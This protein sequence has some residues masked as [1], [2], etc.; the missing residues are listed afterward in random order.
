VSLESI[1]VQRDILNFQMIKKSQEET[2]FYVALKNWTA[3]EIQVHINFTDP[4][5][6]SLSENQDEFLIQVL[7]PRLFVSKDLQ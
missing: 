7:D 6:V 3:S 1:N 2:N 5:N 4:Q